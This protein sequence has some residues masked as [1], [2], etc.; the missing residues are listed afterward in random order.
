MDFSA[1]LRPEMITALS[2][3][4]GAL[5][6]GVVAVVAEIRRPEKAIQAA[7]EA[8]GEAVR[9]AADKQPK[10]PEPDKIS[11]VVREECDHVNRSVWIVEKK[12]SDR[13]HAMEKALEALS[14][15]L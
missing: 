11:R 4:L 7:K 15:R 14:A 6:G 10:P 12:L 5:L 13:M 1:L 2:V 8:A 3:S 9:E